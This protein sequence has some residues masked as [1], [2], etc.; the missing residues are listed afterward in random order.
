MDVASLQ[1]VGLPKNVFPIL[2]LLKCDNYWPMMGLVMGYVQ[3]TYLHP[4]T[5]GP[6]CRRDAFIRDISL[7]TAMVPLKMLTTWFRIK[8]FRVY[9]CTSLAQQHGRRLSLLP[10]DTV[11]DQVVSLVHLKIIHFL[12]NVID[13]LQ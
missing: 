3:T 7:F 10:C 6:V 5:S 1:H 2:E 9:I 12:V 13:P 4:A 8:F 11:E